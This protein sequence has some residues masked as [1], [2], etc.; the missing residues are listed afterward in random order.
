MPQIL[1][2]KEPFFKNSL[3][4]GI[5]SIKWQNP[6]WPLI[7]CQ[8]DTRKGLPGSSQRRCMLLC[9]QKDQI[10]NALDHWNDQWERNGQTQEQQQKKPMLKSFLDDMFDIIM[11]YYEK[12]AR[13]LWVRLHFFHTDFP[14]STDELGTPH[15][16]FCFISQVDG[17]SCPGNS[18]PQ[19]DAFPGLKES[20]TFILFISIH[21]VVGTWY[22]SMI[23][24]LVHN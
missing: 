13:W 7:L 8:S 21:S 4:I 16:G 5:A 9:H 24:V 22:V 19:T 12:H 23:C 11:Q 2:P 1:P 10:I 3:S 18:S 14:T 6:K 20:L 17:S 15:L